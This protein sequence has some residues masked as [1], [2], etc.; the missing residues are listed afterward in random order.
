MEK[1]ILSIDCGTQSLRALI[2]SAEGELLD[3]TQIEYEPYVSPKPGWA[4]QDPEIYW[5]SLCRG[6]KTLK[7]RNP[8]LFARIEGVGVTTIRN[9]LVNVDENGK[10]LRSII[11]WLD[12]RKAD[13]VYSPKGLMK[14]I[15][16]SVGMSEAIDKIQTDG[17]CNWIKQHEP[18]IWEKTK[19]YLQVSGFFNFRLTGNFIDSIASQ[20]GHIPFNYK[21][22]KWASKRT[23][24]AL[25]FPVEKEKLPDTVKPGEPVGRIVREASVQTG[26][27]EGVLDFFPLRKILDRAVLRGRFVRSRRSSSDRLDLF[28]KAAII[29]C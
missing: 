23:L 14:L 17:K 3:K 20:I 25:L 16:R 27:A 13:A 22:M 1:V 24:S 12:Q 4:E 5:Q 29:S 8:G 21:K 7:E 28:R 2:F 10:P 9:S 26:I 18:E 15:Y 19:K 6:C 11:M